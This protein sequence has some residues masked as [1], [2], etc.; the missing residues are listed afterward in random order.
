MK[1]LLLYQY[2]L[3]S[4]HGH[5]YTL[6]TLLCSKRGCLQEHIKDEPID[7]DGEYK[8]PVGNAEN[9]KRLQET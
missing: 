5:P 7:R 9:F 8:L 4:E 6:R 3:D 2:K 1:R